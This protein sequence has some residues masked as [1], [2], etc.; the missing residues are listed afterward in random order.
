MSYVVFR[1]ISA[2]LLVAFVVCSPLTGIRTVDAEEFP[3]LREPIQK[4]ME[5][6]QAIGLAIAVVK[7]GAPLHAESF[8]LRNLETKEPLQ[9]EDIF[10]IASI[11]KSFSATS[12]LQ[13]VEAG[14]LRLSDDVSGL[15]GFPIRNPSHPDVPITLEML[16][17]HTSSLNDSQGYFTL[18][19]IDPSKESYSP[20]SFSPKKPGTE[21]RYCNLNFNL[22]GAI[23][24]RASG[25]RFDRYVA[26]RIL[27]PLGLYGGYHVDSLDAKRF[28]T[29]Y[30]YDAKT[31][32]FNAAPNAYHPRR[33][34]IER[35]V[36]GYS[37]PIFS[38]TGGMKISAKD[39][40]R[41]MTMHMN[42]GHM[43]MGDLDGVRIL[44]AEHAKRMQTPVLE[45]SRYGLAI[46]TSDKLIPGK[47]LKG[48]TG[49]AYGLYSMMFFSPEEKFGLVLITNGCDPKQS[50]GHTE[51]LKLAARLVYQ[52]WIATPST[53]PLTK[54]ERP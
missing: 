44:S 30:E 22:V 39:L 43:R 35:Y 19:V 26:N 51:F 24:E 1:G 31:K 54:I 45:S 11:S 8:G 6:Y 2:A 3:S 13:L 16:L 28:V 14:K 32:A 53:V 47:T 25:E 15:A 29:L 18:D 46:T 5:E 7:E 23:I 9:T 52:Q 21:H 48:H 37:T 17:S 42:M 33:E 27:Q 20:K 12:V 40:A 49:S 4:L 50:E 10:R 34:E 36:F 38:P 41:Y